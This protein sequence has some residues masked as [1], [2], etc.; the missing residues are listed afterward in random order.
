[1]AYFAN[2]LFVRNLSPQVTEVIIREVFAGCDAIEKVSFRP[3]PNSETQFFAQIDFKTSAG[4]SEGS[5][6]SGTKILGVACMCGVIDP[7]RQD[8]P[9]VNSLGTELVTSFKQEFP[10]LVADAKVKAIVV[11][12]K[13]AMFCG[14]A[15]ITEFAVMVAMGAEKMKE[16]NPV[17]ALSEMMDLIDASPKTTVAALNGPALGGGC[18]VNLGLLPGAQGTQRLPRVAPLPTAMQMILQGKPLKADAAKKNGIIDLV[19]AKDVLEEAAEFALSHPPNPISKR[20]VPKTNRFMVAAGALESG[21]NTAVKAAPLMIAPRSIIKCFEAACSKKSF[22]E[23]LQVEMEEFTKLVFSVESAALRHLFLSERLAQKVPGIDEKPAPLK[24]IG[25]LGA[26]LMGGGIAM[27]FVQKG[28]PVVLKDAQQDWLDAGMKKIE[29]LWA[30]QLKK[31]RINEGFKI[32]EE[33]YVARSSDIDIAYIYGYGFPPSK[34]GPMFFAEN[35]TGFKK[36]LEKLKV[37]DA[38]AKERYTKNSKYLPVHYFE[39]SKLLEACAAKEGT[40]VF[41]GQT[42]I[43]VVLKDLRVIPTERLQKERRRRPRPLL[44]ALSDSKAVS[45]AGSGSAARLAFDG[46]PREAEQAKQATGQVVAA[47]LPTEEE[48]AAEDHEVKAEH[49]RK[50]KEAAEEFRLRTCHIAGLAEDTKKDIV[51]SLCEGFGEVEN[52]RI[53]TAADGTTFGLVEFKEIKVAHVVKMQRSF[54]VEDRVLV[55]TE[56]KSHVDN[57]KVQEMMVQFQAPIIDAMEMRSVL[58]QQVPLAEKL[59]KAGLP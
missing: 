13:G 37:F 22:R 36:I 56:A 53:D 46:N 31:G 5:K 49:L 32:L 10:K 17:A 3:Y 8:S 15:E 44:Q 14:G 30:G 33:G 2:S 34:G 20:E 21:L 40:K 23:G 28:V 6:L 58:A 1:M 16:N 47:T 27:C 12:G 52:L 42:L 55:F 50:A 39:P 29:S 11:T 25:I 57:A 45:S 38:Q 54:L 7:V 26:G 24:K 43:D 41:P 35:Y 48:M 51:R 19:A 4:V 9:P 59:A 18:E